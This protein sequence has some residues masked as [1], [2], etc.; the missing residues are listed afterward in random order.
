MLQF[1]KNQAQKINAVIMGRKTWESIPL[2]KRP[3]KNRMNVILS[4]NP[5]KLTEEIQAQHGD[6]MPENVMVVS[7]F[8]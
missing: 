5:E 7:D 8:K 6:A 1:Q 4:T 2:D 3:L